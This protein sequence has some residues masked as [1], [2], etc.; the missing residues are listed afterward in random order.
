MLRGAVKTEADFWAC[1]VC[2][3]IN[4]IRSDRCYSC[5]TPRAVA[6]A[7]PTDLSVTERE[8]PP[9]ITSVYRS[10]EARA[11]AVS[12]ATIG[13]ILAT[14][15]ALWVTWTIG[16]ARAVDGRRAA[17][18]VQAERWPLLLLAPITGVLALVAYAAWI[19]R[20]V[21]NL[22]ALGG[23]YSRVSPTMA[24]I[25]PLIPGVNLYSL[26]ARTAEAV[27]KLEGASQT[28][29]LI[30]IAF[31]L[32]VGPPI[33]AALAIRGASLF[34]SRAELTRTIA[35]ALIGSFS[36]Q[37]I[38]LLVGLA[39]VWQIE[40]LCRTRAERAIEPGRTATSSEPVG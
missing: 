17:E 8:P 2:R 32:V 18:L 28:F 3:S 35:N 39:V 4:P 40:G 30:A 31:L 15:L 33:V 29:A 26:P 23:G 13:F 38:G 6:G 19:S 11:V 22:P 12:I 7:R 21:E 14:F 20:V 1:R 24:F 10:T 16:D 9:A 25:E 37:S 27:R 5:H 36:I 34:E